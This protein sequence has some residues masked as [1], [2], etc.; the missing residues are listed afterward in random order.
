MLIL[1]R[2]KY[3]SILI[4]NDIKVTVIEVMGGQVKLGIE[5]PKEIHVVREEL[6]QQEAMNSNSGKI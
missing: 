5:A 1:T 3:E 4:G 2:R 6:L